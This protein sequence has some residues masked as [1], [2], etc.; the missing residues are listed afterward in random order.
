MSKDFIVEKVVEALDMKKGQAKE[1]VDLVLKTLEEQI[2]V[3]DVVKFT[4]F[5]NFSKVQRA[6]RKG[7]NPK[8]GEEIQIP[9]TVTVKFTPSK[10]LKGKVNPE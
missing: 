1:L 9:A 4:G 7:R 2:I 3:E 5:G 8:T 10:I 6:A